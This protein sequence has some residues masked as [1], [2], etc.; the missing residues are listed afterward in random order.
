MMPKNV[1]NATFG[2]Q[3][4]NFTYKS[5]ENGLAFA[6]DPKITLHFAYNYMHL[7]GSNCS[8]HE[9]KFVQFYALCRFEANYPTAGIC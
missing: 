2:F 7:I 1:K 3:I 6:S 8:H 5:V 4:L 9:C